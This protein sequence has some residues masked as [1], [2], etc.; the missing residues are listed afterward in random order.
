MAASSNHIDVNSSG[1][2]QEL[3]GED[4]TRLSVINF[5]AP[6]AAPCEQ[7]NAVCLELANKYQQVLFLKACQPSS[8]SFILLQS[9]PSFFSRTH[10][11]SVASILEVPHMSFITLSLTFHTESLTFTQVEAE[12]QSE[13]SE[14]F[15]IEAV[16][17]FLI[18]RGHTLLDRISGADA[19]TLT[20][21]VERHS[22]K[23]TVVPQSTTDKAPPPAS[24]DVGD[25]ADNETPEELADRLQ[26]V[27]FP[28]YAH[29]P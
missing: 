14:S 20:S 25:Y 12:S 22:K 9:R 29:R 1:H 4:L 28:F 8:S 7:M 5:W 23:P 21:A 6:W 19:P 26:Y 2:F 24:A 11:S 27:P 10:P 15:D 16:P 17:S 13:I 3:M 18:L